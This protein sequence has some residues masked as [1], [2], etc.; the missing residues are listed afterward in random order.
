[1][2]HCVRG[3]I[4]AG[5]ALAASHAQAQASA[6]EERL[7]DQL[8]QT[9]VQ[10][11]DAQDSMA[12]LKAQLD[13]A[14]AQLEAQRPALAAPP[15]KPNS[16]ETT[17]L[18]AAVEER[19]Q[20]ISE[21]QQRL[22]DSQK[23]L[24]QWQQAYQQAAGLAKARDADAKK[25]EGLYGEAR[26]RGDTCAKDNAELVEISRQLLDRYKKKGV[27]AALKDD[28][29]ITQM[30]RIRLEALAQDYHAEI[31]DHALPAPTEPTPTEA[32]RPAE[33]PK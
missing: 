22:E 10:L 31:E 29:P 28:E 6:T 24:A 2:R 12:D 26:T 18:R 9:T 33:A 17:T 19:N 16:T 3:A 13:K 25:F 21:V 5:W 23:L 20:R 1:M 30:H 4:I 11:R 15:A 32:P 14:N 8:R 7:R 27:W